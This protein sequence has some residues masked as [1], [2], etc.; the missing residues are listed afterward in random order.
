VL[1]ILTI[2]PADQVADKVLSIK[3]GF[4][5]WYQNSC[6]AGAKTKWDAFWRYFRNSLTPSYG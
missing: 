1:D 3:V 4:C 5:F 6:P 2:I